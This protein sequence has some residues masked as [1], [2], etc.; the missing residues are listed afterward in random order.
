METT[1]KERVWALG[2]SLDNFK[3]SVTSC[4]VANILDSHTA[5]VE[6]LQ[7]SNKKFES[8]SQKSKN[9]SMKEFKDSRSFLQQ[10]F[11]TRAGINT[12]CSCKQ[13]TNQ[14]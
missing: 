6:A 4:N 7:N 8:L 2:K 14:Q 11:D 10:Y 12:V 3:K 5:F 1:Y 13:A 9:E